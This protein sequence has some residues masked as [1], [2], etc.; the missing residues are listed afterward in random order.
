M[1]SLLSAS[2]FNLSFS[3]GELLVRRTDRGV[4]P[5]WTNLVGGGIKSFQRPTKPE[6]NPKNMLTSFMNSPT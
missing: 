6:K 4:R 1:R 5:T 3:S 2:H